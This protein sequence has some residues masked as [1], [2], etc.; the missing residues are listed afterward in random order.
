M[1]GSLAG[2]R[3]S[4]LIVLL[5]CL[6]GAGFSSGA[7]RECFWPQFHGP[8]RDNMSTEKGLLKSWPEGGPERLWTAE[9]LGHGFSTVSIA[10]G[11]IYTAGNIDKET[12]ITALNMDGAVQWQA[13]NGPA[14]TRDYPGTRSTPTIDGE[15]LYHQSPLGSVIC[16]KA[17]T[18]EQ[19]WQVNVIEKFR[20][21]NS[22]WALAESLLV[23]GDRVI[24]CP[25]GPQTCMVAL[26][27]H[28]S[29]VVWKTPST[30]EL[31]GYSSPILVEQEGLRMVMTLTAKAFIGVN[32]DTGELLWHIKHESYAD[33]N[34][35]MPVYHDGE[36]FVST[37]K[38]GSVKWKISVE[39][40]KASLEGLWRTEEMDNHHGGV[41]LVGG[42]LYGTSTFR[43]R[44]LWVCLDWQTGR[45]KHMDK[46][47]GK[48]SIMYADGMLYTFSEDSVMGLVRPTADGQQLVSSFRI[49]S[50]GRGKSW[51]HPVVC[52]GR[53]YLRHGDFLYA[54]AIR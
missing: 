17:K 53:L 27:K 8:G 10:S 32:A 21:K 47:V 1:F 35:S 39:G 22:K 54:Y 40:E 25:G 33:E 12:V 14:W 6:P 11:M 31:A 20:S 46:G 19:I 7:G 3:Q 4:V 44:N 34:I 50:G 15:R 52:G 49:P 37:L 16:L 13:R 18:G 38:A 23:D 2:I 5:I 43:N 41:V 48:G 24:C 29:E 9:G 42:N 28:T 36:V 45:S 51:A 30:D 26:N